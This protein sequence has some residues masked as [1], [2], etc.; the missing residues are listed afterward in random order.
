MARAAK[1]RPLRPGATK[2]LLHGDC[3]VSQPGHP[4]YP[5]AVGTRDSQDR[6]PS[7][8]HLEGWHGELE[9]LHPR[10]AVVTTIRVVRLARHLGGL[11]PTILDR[12]VRALLDAEVRSSVMASTGNHLFSTAF[13]CARGGAA[14]HALQ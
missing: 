8:D 5:S 4:L 1:R 14:L 13:Q 6:P 7:V 12:V 10:N 9:S 11:K 3:A 2:A